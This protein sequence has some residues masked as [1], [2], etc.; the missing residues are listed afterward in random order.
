MAIE[1]SADNT[2]NPYGIVLPN[3]YALITG[4]SA[5]DLTTW[6]VTLSVYGSLAAYQAGALPGWTHKFNVSPPA[7]TA[8]QL[9]SEI[10]TQMM[11]LP[12]VTSITQV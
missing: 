7:G 4:F 11:T 1:F 12:G 5:V 6:T 3:C 2:S 10:I 8:A 9:E